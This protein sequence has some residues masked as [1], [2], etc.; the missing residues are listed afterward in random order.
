MK[1]V[2]TTI[3]IFFFL[4][5]SLKAQ[6]IQ[7]LSDLQGKPLV[8]STFSD[9]TGSPYLLDD[10]SKGIVEQGSKVSYKN[11]DLKYNLFKDELFFKNPKDGE[12]L[13][14][15]LPVTGFSLTL[16][17]KIE[18][19]RNGFPEIDN[20][21]RKSYY[22]VLFDG[23]IKLLFKNHR[24]MQEVK[25]YNSPT[26]EKKFID[27]AIYYV[28]RDNVMTKFKPSKKDFLEM[29]KSK[30]AEIADFIKNEKIDFKKHDDLTKVFVFYNTL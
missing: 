26:T 6:F 17:D 27:N 21:N 12:M 2:N 16:Q 13:G 23:G 11:V 14:F 20:F 28:F 25:P 10:W 22:Q 18:I 15:V 7:N 1:I 5:F 30:S 19:Y 29:F 9:V 24:T 8:E 3:L 4:T